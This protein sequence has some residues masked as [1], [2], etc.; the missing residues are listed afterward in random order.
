MYAAGEEIKCKI[1]KS[2]LERMCEHDA[3][4]R[5]GLKDMIQ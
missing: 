1:K 2:K 3:T 4:R 5:D